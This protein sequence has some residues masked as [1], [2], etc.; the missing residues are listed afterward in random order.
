MN[1]RQDETMHI[2]VDITELSNRENVP[3]E[4]SESYIFE[5]CSNDLNCYG[6]S[7]RY[8]GT[9]CT[10]I[11]NQSPIEAGPSKSQFS[12]VLNMSR[13]LLPCC[14]V[15]KDAY[16]SIGYHEESTAIVSDAKTDKNAINDTIQD[17]YVRNLT[18]ERGDNYKCDDMPHPARTRLDDVPS[19]AT[20]TNSNLKCSANCKQTFSEFNAFIE[21]KLKPR[22]FT[23]TK[24]DLS[25]YKIEDIPRYE[26][27]Q[28]ECTCNDDSCTHFADNVTK[29][30]VND[31]KTYDVQE[32]HSTDIK[33]LKQSDDNEATDNVKSTAQS[34]PCKT[35]VIIFPRPKFKKV[36][37]DIKDHT[38]DLEKQI[39]SLTNIVKSI[40][41]LSDQTTSTILEKENLTMS[42]PDP[43]KMRTEKFADMNNNNNRVHIKQQDTEGS[44]LDKDKK[45]LANLTISLP[46]PTVR[47]TQIKP[48]EKN[49]KI[50][51][52]VEKKKQVPTV[53]TT[54]DKGKDKLDQINLKCSPQDS[55]SV[56]RKS[57]V[58][59]IVDKARDK[60]DQINFKSTAHN[61]YN[62]EQETYS[63]KKH[64][65]PIEDDKIEN[66]I[67]STNVKLKTKDINDRKNYNTASSYHS[68]MKTTI[69][70]RDRLYDL[71]S[72]TTR[73]RSS[74]LSNYPIVVD[75]PSKLNSNAE[76]ID[77][78]SMN[79]LGKESNHDVKVIP[80]SL[81][82]S[83]T[84]DG[85]Q[86]SISI[87]CIRISNSSNCC[88]ADLQTL[89]VKNP[90]PRDNS[91][92]VTKMKKIRRSKLGKS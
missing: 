83:T 16:S 59:T 37:S 41:I 28:H 39:A 85:L 51:S 44:N 21:R 89:E 7:C 35:I 70:N 38:K 74:R 58:E 61:C 87:Q 55:H 49:D 47:T 20:N 76:P 12:N 86:A 57:I 19:T 30:I 15:P 43:E 31:T 4:L 22:D 72:Q 34:S 1:D 71:C 77:F 6:K 13:K 82:A 52:Y 2:P 24:E 91:Y 66:N 67:E 3:V 25:N 27:I 18:K 11:S 68:R 8:N 80:A 10:D 54:A 50:G 5:P 33:S 62:I 29:M 90:P 14:T 88:I 23:D 46:D 79:N 53:E 9:Q 81:N 36:V 40:I 92:K 84:I 42:Y 60:P 64:T 48:I 56:E 26:E 75:T 17:I 78:T 32:T 69:S 45:P 65:C 73:T 63:H